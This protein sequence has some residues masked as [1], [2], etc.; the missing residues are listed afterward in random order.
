[1]LE[2]VELKD[3]MIRKKFSYK[4][5]DTDVYDHGIITD[6]FPDNIY[7]KMK[8][9]GEY[10]ILKTKKNSLLYLEYLEICWL[11]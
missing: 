2:I 4:R 9:S 1:M 3:S 11:F 5:L 7:Y 8:N 10:K 6:E